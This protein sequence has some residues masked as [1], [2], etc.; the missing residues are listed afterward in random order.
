MEECEAIVAVTG[1]QINDCGSVSG[2]ET[3]T[4]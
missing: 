2:G 1:L 4:V 3:G